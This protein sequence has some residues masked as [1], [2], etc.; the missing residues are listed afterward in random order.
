MGPENRLRV[1]PSSRPAAEL[2]RSRASWARRTPRPAAGPRRRARFNGAGPR[3]PGEQLRQV[4]VRRHAVALQRSRASWARRTSASP[5]IL[6]TACAL[7]RSRASWARRT[8]DVL[9][10]DPRTEGF[11]GAG[12]RGPGELE[13]WQ[14]VTGR[15]AA[16][17]EPGLVGPENSPREEIQLGRC[18]CFNGAGPRGPGEPT[19]VPGFG[20]SGFRF[21]GAGPRGPGER[22]PPAFGFAWN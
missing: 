5:L 16:S 8:G 20:C 15:K 2:Q 14:R 3:G 1:R 10:T 4:P 7:Q 18:T 17:T 19:E 13:R 22:R 11:N 6:C 21:N 12:P 9:W